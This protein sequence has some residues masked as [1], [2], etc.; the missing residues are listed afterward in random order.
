MI[1]FQLHYN[2]TT[3]LSV[4]KHIELSYIAVNANGSSE[5]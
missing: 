1:R 5:M 3:K 4:E 2:L